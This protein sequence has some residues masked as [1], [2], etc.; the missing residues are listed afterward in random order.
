MLNTFNSPKLNGAIVNVVAS[1]ASVLLIN[2]AIFGLRWSSINSFQLL[3]PTVLP[4]F[5]PPGY[6]I[7]MVWT[8]L[9]GLMGTSRWLLNKVQNSQRTNHQQLVVFLILFCLV[10]PLYSLAINSRLGA[11]IGNLGT[12]LLATF[13]YL[14]ISRSSKQA[15]LLV[16]PTIV[17]VT[18]AT[19]IL[20]VVIQARGW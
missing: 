6:A 15:A 19:V 8:L 17:W 1:I 2:A 10:Y 11:L 9:F 4:A 13:T 20:V 3:D 18:Y 16:L 14:K 5:T 12:I 7:G